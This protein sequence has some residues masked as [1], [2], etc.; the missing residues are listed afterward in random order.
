MT[1]QLDEGEAVSRRAI[2]HPVTEANRE[3]ASATDHLAAFA[4]SGRLSDLEALHGS[5]VDAYRHVAQAIDQA[6]RKS[7]LDYDESHRTDTPRELIRD[8]AERIKETYDEPVRPVALQLLE[9]NRRAW[10]HRKPGTYGAKAVARH[11]LTANQRRWLNAL[12]DA[13]EEVGE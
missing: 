7:R 1:P 9:A 6:E 10:L 11:G 2:Y 12:Q 13:V 3:L 4:H 8:H 5:L